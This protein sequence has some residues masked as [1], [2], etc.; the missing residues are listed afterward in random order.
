M[1][2]P[3]QLPTVSRIPKGHESGF[4]VGGFKRLIW[5]SKGWWAQRCSS[6]FWMFLAFFPFKRMTRRGQQEEP[7]PDTALTGAAR[8]VGDMPFHALRRVL[9]VGSQM[10]RRDE[11]LLSLAALN[12]TRRS[13]RFCSFFPRFHSNDCS[14][15]Q[16][17]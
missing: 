1:P 3:E 17:Y 16:L 6:G 13:H 12:W 5:V 4:K 2:G 9:S 7:R 10:W 15:H 14:E 11:E 8:D